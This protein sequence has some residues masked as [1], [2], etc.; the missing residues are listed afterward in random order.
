LLVLPGAFPQEQDGHGREL[1]VVPD[2]LAEN[3]PFSLR[4]V[5]VAEEEIRGL[6]ADLREGLVP[7]GRNLNP[8]RT[9]ELL[10]KKGAQFIVVFYEKNR[11]RACG[12]DE[13]RVGL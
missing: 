1:G 9:G 12:H 11:R 5:G 3:G 10:L 4:H 6:L 7:I 13:K 8:M 2:A